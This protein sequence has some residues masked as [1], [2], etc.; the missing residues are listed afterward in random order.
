MGKPL[1]LSAL[2]FSTALIS[3]FELR[4]A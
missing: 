4:T 2:I 1:V 3:G